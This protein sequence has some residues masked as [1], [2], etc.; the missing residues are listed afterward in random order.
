MPI[1]VGMIT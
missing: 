1:F